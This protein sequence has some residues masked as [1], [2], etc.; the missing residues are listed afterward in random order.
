MGRIVCKSVATTQVPAYL[1]VRTS[2]MDAKIFAW[3]D[4]LSSMLKAQRMVGKHLLFF[5]LL[6]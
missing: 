4:E 2:G 5:I 1:S 6:V 3:F